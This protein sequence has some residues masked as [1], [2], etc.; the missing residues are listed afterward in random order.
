MRNWSAI[1]IGM[2]DGKEI[3]GISR[4]LHISRKLL[5]FQTPHHNGCIKEK[6]Q[7]TSS[8]IKLPM[9]MTQY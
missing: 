1:T 7:Y 3:G 8:S 5:S 2:W 6:Y 4:L 9:E